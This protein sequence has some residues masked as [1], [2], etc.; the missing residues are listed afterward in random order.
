MKP[1]GAECR[2]VALDIDGT[3]MAFD[4][5]ISDE[6]HAAIAAL[7]T[8]GHVVVLS[9]GRP[10]VATLPVAR[11]LGIEDGW[12]V[13]SNGSVTAR[14]DSSSPQGYALDDEVLFDPLPALGVMRTHMPT[15]KVALEEVGVG[16]WVTQ[17]FDDPNLHGTHTVLGPEEIGVRRTT[18]VVVADAAP[19]SDAF[20]L[21]VARLGLV[22]THFTI[23]QTRWM[24]LAPRGVTK[25]FALERLRR[26]LRLDPQRTVAV[27]DGANDVEMLQWAGLGVAMGHAPAEVVSAADL[28][29]GS[30]VDDGVLPVLRGVLEP[31]S[32]L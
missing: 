19:R 27:G 8:A 30:I 31:G 29:T 17:A 3:V 23:A 7:R 28:V 9:T 5:F 20:G 12:V 21:A 4:E 1:A 10:L 14:L 2:L 26:L 13:C 24:D 25:A 22:D 32:S 16:Y 15:A 11:R 18:R 6:V